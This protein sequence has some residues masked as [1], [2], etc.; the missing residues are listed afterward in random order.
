MADYEKKSIREIVENIN[1]RYF[2][3][4]IQRNFV[5]SKDQIYKL[6]DSLMRG[7]PINTMLF[8]EIDKLKSE[9]IN[10][11]YDVQILKF[12]LNGNISEKNDSITEKNISMNPYYLVLDGQQRLTSLNMSLRGKYFENKKPKE[13]YFY[14]KSSN[15]DLDD[16]KYQFEFKQNSDDRFWV[17]V[18][19]I[20]NMS[21]KELERFIDNFEDIKSDN[22]DLFYDIK[23]NLNALYKIFN[24]NLYFYSEKETNYDKILD[25]FVRTNS[26]GTQLSYS[27]LLFSKIKLTWKDAKDEIDNLLENINENNF[28]FDTDFVLKTFLFLTAGNRQEEIKFK[29]ENFEQEKVN[30]F[31]E[32]WKEIKSA[33][34]HMKDL[35][36]SIG[37]KDGKMLSSNN[38][39]IPL[40]YYIFKNNIKNEQALEKQI[41]PIKKFTFSTLLAGTF[42]GQSDTILYHFK[43]VIDDNPGN[44]PVIQLNKKLKEQQKSLELSED[45]LLR[46]KYGS[47]NSHLIL[48]L[49]KPNYKFKASNKSNTVHQ[50]HIFSQKELRN[51]GISVKETNSLG[52]LRYTTANE[53][54]VKSG[55]NYLEWVEKLSSEEKEKEFIPKGEFNIDNFSDFILE[56]IKIIKFKLEGKLKLY[57]E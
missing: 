29:V 43:K 40:I 41:T 42:G 55:I 45:F 2:L 18:P 35:L 23:D 28:K 50:D 12:I 56:R 4:D 24:E 57:D 1:V 8:W 3:P 51:N 16:L 5:W 34:E 7:Y 9:E 15:D 53:N 26:G 13:L 30:Q 11:L 17:N 19:E 39:V 38:A 37:I 20:F 47:S 10:N 21:P 49:L 31:I 36:E 22:K 48:S 32:K 54:Q 52:N 44:Y 33:I 25:I 46:I 14:I 6:F 27:D